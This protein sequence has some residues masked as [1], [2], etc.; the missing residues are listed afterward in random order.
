MPRELLLLREMRDSAV[1]IRELVGDRSVDLMR[2]SARLWHFTV[3]GAIA[4]AQRYG[5]EGA[6]SALLGRSCATWDG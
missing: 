1:A 3:L 2:R 5:H 6:A 4:A